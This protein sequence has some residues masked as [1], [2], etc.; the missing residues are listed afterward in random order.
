MSM[1]KNSYMNITLQIVI[2]PFQT[3][4]EDKD[5]FLFPKALLRS[6]VQIMHICKLWIIL[7]ALLH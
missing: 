7:W 3:G 2:I 4:F 6:W 1:K 5:I